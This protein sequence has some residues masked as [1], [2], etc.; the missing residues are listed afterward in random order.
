MH[1]GVIYPATRKGA[2]HNLDEYCSH[3][4]IANEG[5]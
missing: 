4:L 3:H 2:I 5:A 1:P